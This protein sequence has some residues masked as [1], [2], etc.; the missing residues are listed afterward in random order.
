[1][2][3]VVEFGIFSI[4][5]VVEVRNINETKNRLL[6][7]NA[8]QQKKILDA[9]VEGA[10]K[11]RTRL[12][13]ELHDN[14]GSR[15]ALLKNQIA[16]RV[17]S[18]DEIISDIGELYKNVR[19]LSHELSPG[20]FNVIR[21]EEY[22]PIY[23]EKIENTSRIKTKFIYRNVPLLNTNIYSQLFRIIQE[24]VQKCTETFPG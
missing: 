23:L 11:E 22:L 20:N 24:A 16:V 14:I 19:S 4:A 5:L 12:S 3:S 2:G 9:Y 10:E 8:E 21:F 17:E 7:A 6:A 13:G 15:L 1:L 18:E